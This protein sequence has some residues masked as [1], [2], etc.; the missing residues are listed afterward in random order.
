[1]ALVACLFATTVFGQQKVIPAQCPTIVAGGDYNNGT[2][3]T[4]VKNWVAANMP[5]YSGLD[6]VQTA[7]GA[8]DS[9]R[10]K[11]VGEYNHVNFET[12]ATIYTGTSCDS[13]YVYYWGTCTQGNGQ[14]SWKLLQSTTLTASTSEQVVTLLPN[15]GVGNP[16]TNYRVTVDVADLA[17]TCKVYWRS[18]LLVR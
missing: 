17:G 12:H 7:V 16:Y 3:D 10:E 15:G 4:A 14:G 11:L 5:I 18:W 8:G 1:M 2:V 13:V 6:T 9:V